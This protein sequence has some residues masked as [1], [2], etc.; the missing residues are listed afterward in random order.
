MHCVMV[1]LINLLSSIN[2]TFTIIPAV[3]ILRIIHVLYLQGEYNTV[4]ILCRVEASPDPDH[5]AAVIMAV[6][7]LLFLSA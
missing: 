4:G 3:L 2:L 6:N 5:L 1:S 7:I